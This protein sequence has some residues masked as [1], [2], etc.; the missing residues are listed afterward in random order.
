MVSLHR[1]TVHLVCD[2]GVLFLLGCS[3]LLSFFGISSQCVL[4]CIVHWVLLHRKLWERHLGHFSV[5]KHQLAFG[6]EWCWSDRSRFAK[7]RGGESHR[8]SELDS[9]VR[10]GKRD[11]PILL[12]CSRLTNRAVDIR[13]HI[14]H[15][16]LWHTCVVSCGFDKLDR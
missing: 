11:H 13:R 7:L 16:S 10:V 12:D 3:E 4:T 6:A 15:R 1:V 14:W 5:D 9:S 2:R 8:S